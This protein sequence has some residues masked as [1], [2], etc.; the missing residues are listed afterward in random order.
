MAAA[1]ATSCVESRSNTRRVS[2]S[3]PAVTSSPVRQQM[4]W[5]PC[6]AAPAISAWSASRLRSRQVSCMTG[7]M[8]SCFSAIAI[9][10]GDACACAE[11]LSVALTASTQSS[12]GWKWPCT[13]S[14]PP[15]STV[16]SSAVRTKRPS[17]SASSSLDIRLP[18]L[19]RQLVALREEVLPRRGAPET[20][21]DGRA[22]VVDLLGPGQLSRALDR[23]HPHTAPLRLDLAMAVGPHTAA[24]PV[25]ELLRACHRAGEPGRVQDALAAHVAA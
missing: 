10:S 3:S 7:S 17:A 4:F 21:V 16:R 13:A 18:A 11:V 6:S 9:E 15:E 22:Q 24:R 23:L 8:P 14:S 1:V 25:A 20:V 19:R 12:Y 5:M 2:G